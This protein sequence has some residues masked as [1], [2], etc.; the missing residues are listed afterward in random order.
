MLFVVVEQF[1]AVASLYVGSR[2]LVLDYVSDEGLCCPVV[3]IAADSEGES[4]THGG[5]WLS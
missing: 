4:S 5:Q 3:V 2:L 1:D